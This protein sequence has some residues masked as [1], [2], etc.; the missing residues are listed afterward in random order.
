MSVGVR[1]SKGAALTANEVI[2]QH[3]TAP[4]PLRS[5]I[6]EESD[7]QKVVEHEDERVLAA[8]RKKTAP[9]SFA[10]SDFEPDNSN[11]SGS[12]THHSASPLTTIIPN[13]TKPVAAGSNLA[14]ESVNRP[15]VGTG[16]NIDK[17]RNDAEVNSPHSASSPHS[18]HS[19]QSQHSAHSDK[20][21]QTRS[22][23]DELY[24]NDRGEYAYG[25]ASGSTACLVFPQ[26]NPGGDTPGSSIRAYVAPV[27]P[28]IPAWNL[29]IQS[30]LNDAESC[31]DMMINLA[32]PVVRDQQNRFSDYQALQRSWL[33][34][35]QNQLVD[36][37]RSWSKLSDDHKILQQEHLG[38]AGKEAALVDKLA[39]TE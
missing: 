24:Y 18:E 20:D 2:A 8:Q 14:L 26:R 6:F 9:M 16:S 11:R 12:G 13:D 25:H 37:I 28:F 23:G 3:T 39:T 38:C 5:Q 1:I 35:T 10:L 31:R 4:L 7:Y 17:P 27:D 34:D 36:A 19:F 32:T 21:T 29:T 30:I 15:G 33:I 22:G